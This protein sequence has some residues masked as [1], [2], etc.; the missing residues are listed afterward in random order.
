ML[1][2]WPLKNPSG[3]VLGY[4]Y[5]M[6]VCI[7]NTVALP[8][9]HWQYKV[10]LTLSVFRGRSS[11]QRAPVR[12]AAVC[13]T[14]P[15]VS[16]PKSLHRAQPGGGRSLGR[17]PGGRQHA[18]WTF[19]R[20]AQ[21]C[22]AVW[23]PGAHLSDGAASTASSP[24]R[25]AHRHRSERG[26]RRRRGSRWRAG[27]GAA[28]M[29][30]V[31]AARRGRQPPG[32]RPARAAA[33][34]TAFQNGQHGVGWRPRRHRAAAVASPW[35]SAAL[36]YAMLYAL[37]FGAHILFRAAAYAAYYIITAFVL[38]VTASKYLFSVTDPR[39]ALPCMYLMQFSA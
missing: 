26:A 5:C 28:Q 12:A 8:S 21:R 20:R 16:G 6:Y 7:A 29:A 37:S 34:G 17:L 9:Y 38:L 27:G 3:S 22:S 4:T 24:G 39:C 32:R 36:S 2:V 14:D 35:C 25:N 31:A 10:Q 18:D 15:A 11:A 13:L 19:C 30:G 23:V 33:A 1:I